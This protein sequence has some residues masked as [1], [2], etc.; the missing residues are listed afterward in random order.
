MKLILPKRIS[1][2]LASLLFAWL[3]H[4]DTSRDTSIFA[5]REV[6]RGPVDIELQNGMVYSG[7]IEAADAATLHL[8]VT[9]ATRGEAVLTFAKEQV[10][11]L[12]FPGEIYRETLLRWSEDPT[13]NRDALS[14]FRAFYE[15]QIRYLDWLPESALSLFIEYARFALENNEPVIAV[16]IAE[17]IRPHLQ[18]ASMRRHL[19]DALV[20]G[21]LRIGLEAEAAD[22]ARAWIREADPAGDSAM[23]WRVLAEIYFLN[24]QYEDAMWVALL[25]VAYAGAMP[26]AHLSHCY[27]MA[28]LSAIELRQMPMAQRLYHEM[29][30]RALP[31]PDNP[32]MIAVKEPAYL[33]EPEPTVVDADDAND[34]DKNPA[35]TASDSELPQQSPSPVDHMQSLPTRVQF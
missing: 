33:I 35:N 16:A 13:R 12:R 7:R 24:E 21:F 27:A 3:A 32:A 23:G 28:I 25:P 11:Q 20:L 9:V 5:I 2:L 26:T 14:L 30:E 4:A 1:L 10:R 8:A 18:C 29:I 19:D 34:V 31:W 17:E 22:A 15:Q 6:L